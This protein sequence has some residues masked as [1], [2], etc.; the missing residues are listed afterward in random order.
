MKIISGHTYNNNDMKY[1]IARKILK[2]L[3]DCKGNKKL[4]NPYHVEQQKQAYRIFCKHQGFSLRNIILS[5][6]QPWRGYD[7]IRNG[8]V[9]NTT[10]VNFNEFMRLNDEEAQ[11]RALN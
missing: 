1:R 10:I 3:S 7:I 4:D 2:R 8:K 5:I 6:R 9:I 11:N